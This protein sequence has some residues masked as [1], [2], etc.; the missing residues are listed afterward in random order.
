MATTIER[1]KHGLSEEQKHAL[2]DDLV[3]SFGEAEAAWEVYRGH[4]HM[5]GIL[6]AA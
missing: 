2:R 5:H 6:P 3:A 4:L 1:L